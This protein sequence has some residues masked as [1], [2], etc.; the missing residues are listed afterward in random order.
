MPV[1][2]GQ[3]HPLR[4]LQDLETKLLRIAVEELL[5]GNVSKGVSFASAGK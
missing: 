3:A 1:E 5:K 2:F 4:Q